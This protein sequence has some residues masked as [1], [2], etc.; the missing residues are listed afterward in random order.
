M[1]CKVLVTELELRGIFAF[2]GAFWVVV[3][4]QLPTELMT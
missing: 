1:F 4:K 3:R 2:A